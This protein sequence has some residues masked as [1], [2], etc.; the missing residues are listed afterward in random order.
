[1]I[2]DKVYDLI[3]IG[4]GINGAGIARDAAV[5]GLS[6]LLFEKSDFGSGTSWTSTKMIH[7]GLRYL[8]H[9]E[10]YLVRESLREREILLKTAPHLVR[11][12]PFVIPIYKDR[13]YGSTKVKL[14]MI[15]YDVLSFDKSL[16]PHR[17]LS[18]TEF[19]RSDPSITPDG[20]KRVF[21]YYDCQVNY[22]E[23]LCLGNVL[24]ARDCGAQVVNYSRVDGI[25]A[26]RG[27][28]I[29][30]RV[31]DG[32]AKDVY[33]VRGR[34]VVNAAGPWV[35]D[36][37]RL[38]SGSARRKIG[39]TKGSH[40]VTPKIKGGPRSALYAPAKKD[41]RPFVI[42]P[43][44]DYHLIGTTDVRFE[45]NLDDVHADAWE[46]EYL[47]NEA[48]SILSGTTLTES[49]VLYSFAGVRPLPYTEGKREGE[50][51][52]RHIIYDHESEERVRGLISII[53]GKVTTYRNLA[54]QT[55]DLVFKR[56]SRKPAPCRTMTDFLPGGGIED[57]D[58]YMKVNSQKGAEY[59]LESEQVSYL[60]SLYGT[61]FKD[62]I[63]LTEERSELK[64]RICPHNP[65]IKAQVIYAVEHE[66]AKKAEDVLLRRTGIGTS[67][68]LGLDCV[69]EVARLMGGR[70]G[71]DGGRVEREV[72]EYKSRVNAIYRH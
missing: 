20:L 43:W 71:W 19:L 34:V 30:V 50:I 21:I 12:L 24:S 33:E 4:G 38:Q 1:L 15:A 23:R 56:L 11:P 55:V 28:A 61:R 60:I 53:G 39:G 66:L 18:P 47:L 8:E 72:A 63:G 44:R 29:G 46:V 36:V 64:E 57:I 62:V 42:V 59:G 68:C 27:V 5:R 13:I 26:D 45:G 35:D 31:Q 70:L 3:I 48:N 6:V 14:G 40:I 67:T 69:G 16:P 32:S 17:S 2:E 22:P 58:E 65:D 41:G 25:I 49:D 54:E 9:Y 10:F 52:R 7:G 37:C 51:T